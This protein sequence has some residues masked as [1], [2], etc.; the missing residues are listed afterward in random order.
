MTIIITSSNNVLKRISSFCFVWFCGVW[1][2]SRLPGSGEGGFRFNRIREMN[3][4]M[5]VEVIM[6]PVND[7]SIQYVATIHFLIDS[8]P[9]IN[10][11][12]FATRANLILKYHRVWILMVVIKIHDWCG[13]GVLYSA[14]FWMLLNSEFLLTHEEVSFL[15][16]SRKCKFFFGHLMDSCLVYCVHQIWPDTFSPYRGM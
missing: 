16:I 15:S 3:P 11:N 9:V 13:L 7:K 14:S 5:I 2:R 12:H 8:D 6:R 4:L 1:R 10:K